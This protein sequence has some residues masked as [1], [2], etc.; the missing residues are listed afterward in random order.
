MENGLFF[1]CGVYR[2]CEI[3]VSGWVWENGIDVVVFVIKLNGRCSKKFYNREKREMNGRLVVFKVFC[4]VIFLN[5][6]VMSV[7]MN[8]IFIKNIKVGRRF[9]IVRVMS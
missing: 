5:N 6:V 9:C 7:L 4:F 2:Y 1:G 3:F 8:S